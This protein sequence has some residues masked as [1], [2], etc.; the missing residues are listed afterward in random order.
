MLLFMGSMDFRGYKYK[1]EDH[2]GKKSIGHQ[3]KY[4]E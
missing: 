3:Y 2:H 1:M 4:Q